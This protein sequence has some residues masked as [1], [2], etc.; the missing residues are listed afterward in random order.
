MRRGLRPFAPSA[1]RHPGRVHPA[2]RAA[3]ERD[4]DRERKHERNRLHHLAIGFGKTADA[5]ACAF[6]EMR[7]VRQMR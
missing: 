7:L 6:G 1:D 3:F 2:R 4:D 5:P